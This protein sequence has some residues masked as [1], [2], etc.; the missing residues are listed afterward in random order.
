MTTYN[1]IATTALLL[2]LLPA[3]AFADR[4]AALWLQSGGDSERQPALLLNTD[5]DIEVS[6]M[7]AYTLVSQRFVNTSDDWVEGQYLFPL[8]DDSA[9]ESLRIKIGDRLIEGEI[10]ERGQ[11][12]ETYRAA[13]AEGRAA[14]L[15]EQQRGNVFTT[16]V[17]NIAPGE[18]VEIQIGFRQTVQ[19]RH[20][21][22]SL[23]FPTTVAPRFG[24]VTDGGSTVSAPVQPPARGRA[25]TLSLR[26][27]LRPGMAL[28]SLESSHHHIETDYNGDRWLITLADEL[29]EAGKD[30]EL[31]WMPDQ[32]QP[33]HSAVFQQHLG[34]LDHVLLMMVPPEEF[35]SDQT[36]REQ[37]LIIDTSGS[38]KGE[39]IDQA[40]QSLIFA[41]ERL[42]S[43]D[44][45]NVIE[46][47][48][49]ARA[50]FD[51]PVTAGNANIR[52]A[53]RFVNGLRAGGGTDM[54]PPL[55]MAMGFP[56]TTGYIR[57]LVFITDGLVHNEDEVSA[58]V[59]RDI[60]NA[61]LFNVGI[62]HGVNSQ[63]LSDLARYG[64]GTN[65]RIADLDQINRRMGELIV[66]LST[67]VLHD[68]ELH[69][70]G[71]AEVFPRRIPDLYTGEPLVVSA[72]GENLLGDVLVT[73]MSNGRS[74][75][76]MIPMESFQLAGGVAAH[77]G[78]AGIRS[79]LDERFNGAEPD[80]LREGV[81][82]LALEYQLLSPFTSLVAV[83]RTPRRSRQ[84]A[85]RRHDLPTDLPHG[86]ELA[87]VG[88][89]VMIRAMP[90]TDAGSWNAM[91][92]GALAL[93][94]VGLMLGHKRLTREPGRQE[95]R[96]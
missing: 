27:E 28:A 14:G 31:V 59:R 63:F 42:R 4:Q 95:D 77:W 11:A 8:P 34:G 79:R 89:E 19:F 80:Q 5:V 18:T 74:W 73:G 94:L 45:F 93:L 75:Q 53:I 23:D 2:I 82:N 38:M 24:S 16:R 96:S 7:L 30:F 33:I 20:G 68:I 44:R 47:D 56:E 69:W 64:R 26:V 87:G 61:R 83:D 71:Q 88:D 76:Q 51:Q 91:L 92:R 49:D 10:Q 50:L 25:N 21:R 62:G 35:S 40:R 85:L 39:S 58:R 12:R 66:Q 72:R 3:M 60:G 57:Q 43:G 15:V 29:D 41:L 55:D 46:F 65:T 22:F 86:R 37:I 67:P 90:A 6:G 52:R 70:A 17:A 48:Q 1:N 9:V 54:G 84:A 81:L 13:R 32:S 78:H 36:P